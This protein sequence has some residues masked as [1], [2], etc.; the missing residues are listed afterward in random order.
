MSQYVKER[1][2]R[3]AWSRLRKVSFELQKIS[4]IKITDDTLYYAKD[5]LK[6]IK[7]RGVENGKKRSDF[8]SNRMR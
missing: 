2:Q 5:Y 6:K 3:G 4:F 7:R 8:I 1:I